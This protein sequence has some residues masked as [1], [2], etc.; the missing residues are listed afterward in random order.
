MIGFPPRY[1]TTWSFENRSPAEQLTI[2]WLAV[3]KMGWQVSE[4][5]PGSITAFTNFSLR[6]WNE[7]VSI[8]FATEEVSLF[9]VS[10][11]VQ[12]VDFGRNRQNI[13]RLLKT[14][15]AIAAETS[16]ETLHAAYEER[17][18]RIRPEGDAIHLTRSRPVVAGFMQVFMPVK[19]YFIT[20]ILIVLNVFIF[21][22]LTNKWLF[23]ESSG[24]APHQQVL[25]H[26]GASFK[27]LTLFGEP[28]RLVSAAFLH[29]DGLH[30]FF[31]MYAIMVCGIYLEPLLGR[32]RFLL[33][34]LLCAIMASLT[35]LWWYDITPTLGASGAVFGLFGFILTLS[36]HHFL[37]P[38]ERKALLTSIGLY[39][40]LSLSTIFLSTNFDHASHIGGL[41][42]GM[43]LAQLLYAGLQ[44]NATRGV[45]L[46]STALA[47][48]LMLVIISAVYWLLPRDVNDYMT[49]RA[50]LDENYVLASGVF[51]GQND[52]E[53]MRW[54][55][56]YAIYYMDENLRI[57]DEID[58]LSLGY[59]SRQQNKLLRKLYNTRKRIFTMN[60]NT[61]RE[62]RNR[63][64]LQI[65]EAVHELEEIHRELNY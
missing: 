50:R 41:V 40:L 37:E 48:G 62:G 22:L 3:E 52:E 64:D 61:L 55:K 59:D 49:K 27:P 24:W 43:L 23:P 28:W 5:T 39:I 53:R 7:Q 60:Y 34:Y 10:T 38:G 4:V 19:G 54:L 42:A 57:M 56:N 20:P 9:S 13:K 17:Q 2:F 16:P 11:G 32:W 36:L 29:A 45:M 26:F 31:N 58:G 44:K 47:A 35:S 18:P 8:S 21:L 6:S 63:Y 51:R 25:E 1:R 46:R 12:V 30:L 14:V 65:I 33:V 15:A